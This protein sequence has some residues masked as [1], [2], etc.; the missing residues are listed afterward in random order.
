MVATDWREMKAAIR[1]DS[2][3]IPL[4]DN[5]VVD[6][7]QDLGD[8]GGTGN[9]GDALDAIGVGEN[10]DVTGEVRAVGTGKV[11]QHA[12]V[13]SD[14]IDLDFLDSGYHIGPP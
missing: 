7:V 6:L 4:A 9:L 11:E 5:Q 14:G 1:L 3:S 8:L 13:A 10:H 2:V 12:V